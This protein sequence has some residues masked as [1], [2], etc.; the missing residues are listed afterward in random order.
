MRNIFSKKVQLPVPK[1]CKKSS[2][3]LLV[4]ALFVHWRGQIIVLFASSILLRSNLKCFFNLRVGLDSFDDDLHPR[5]AELPRL[6]I[7][8]V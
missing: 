3:L 4:G 1:C 7:L 6:I 2:V 5:V 8:S